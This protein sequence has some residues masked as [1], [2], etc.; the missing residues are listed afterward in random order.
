VDDTSTYIFLL[1]EEACTLFCDWISSVLQN[2][3]VRVITKAQRP[4]YPDLHHPCNLGMVST[5]LPYLKEGFEK[6]SHQQ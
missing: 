5:R 1:W 4:D 2:K 3:F 6:I